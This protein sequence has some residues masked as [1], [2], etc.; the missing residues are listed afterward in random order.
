MSARK[1]DSSKTSAPV[2][3][4]SRQTVL[5]LA[6]DAV[7]V[8]RNGV[9]FHVGTPFQ[10]WVEMTVELES[11]RA[12]RRIRC[13]GIVVSCD[14]SRHA[15]YRVSLLFTGLTPEAEADLQ[16]LATA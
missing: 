5:H 2:V 14:G 13:N 12:G 1:L 16:Q 10:T 7:T 8:R 15:G 4:Q 3:I 11:P 9:E 6:P